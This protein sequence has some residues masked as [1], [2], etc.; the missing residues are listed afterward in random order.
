[1]DEDEP[2]RLVPK[3]EDSVDMNG[4]LLNQL[5]AYDWLLNAEVQMKLD[6]EH[7]MGR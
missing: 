3:I 1:M 4:Q 5:P 7:A 2:A 6:N